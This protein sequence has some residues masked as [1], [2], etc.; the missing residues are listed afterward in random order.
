MKRKLQCVNLPACNKTEISRTSDIMHTS[1]F[2][3]ALLSVEWWA[4]ILILV[5]YTTVSDPVWGTFWIGDENHVT[6]WNAQLLPLCPVDPKLI[7]TAGNAHPSEQPRHPLPRIEH[8]HR[9]NELDP[10]LVWIIGMHGVVGG[11]ASVMVFLQLSSLSLFSPES[12]SCVSTVIC[13]EGY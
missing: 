3:A 2:W 5:T 6:L 9:H 7:M 10:G 4:L 13:K 12:A 8:W 1:I 11:V